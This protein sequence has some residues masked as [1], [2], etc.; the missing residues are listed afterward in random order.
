MRAL[1]L[2][3]LLTL[4]WPFVAVGAGPDEGGR[5]VGGRDALPHEARWT[6]ELAYYDGEHACGG[7]LIA[8]R[9]VLTAA[10]CFD[11]SRPT[12]ALP[13]Y[14]I[15]GT[16]KQAATVLIIDPTAW[17]TQFDPDP[18]HG[19][20][21]V[22]R[23]PSP[24]PCQPYVPNGGDHYARND[25]ALIHLPK[26]PP[27]DDPSCGPDSCRIITIALDDV[28]QGPED[29]HVSI[30]GWGVTSEAASEVS[31]PAAN[32]VLK[33][34][35]LQ[36]LG[37]DDCY[38]QNLR[39]Y[40]RAMSAAS[41]PP[42]VMCAGALPPANGSA[43]ARAAHGKSD[44]VCLGDS[45]G[46]LVRKRFGESVVTG[47]AVWELRCGSGPGLYTRVAMFKDWIAQVIAANGGPG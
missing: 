33:I 8:P 37:P 45:G 18:A 47:V 1:L 14:V 41:W 23:G 7:A 31:H 44:D 46:P 39:R 17:A 28:T 35:E 29:S 40:K 21:F 12:E 38:Q 6:V 11:K 25:I 16:V 26:A 24:I 9:W 30:T 43:K 3:A 27:V 10:H 5:I 22:C 13:N 36:A 42:S 34:A 20:V 15:A 19:Q 32:K 2:A 4:A